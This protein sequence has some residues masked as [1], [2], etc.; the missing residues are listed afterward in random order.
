MKAEE[1]QKSKAKNY[2]QFKIQNQNLGGFK[3]DLENFFQI[4]NILL[5]THRQFAQ[6]RRS[7]QA[8]KFQFSLMFS[9]SSY[10]P[11]PHLLTSNV[12]SSTALYP[13]Q[14]DAN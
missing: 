3:I 7:T 2:L 6:L 13:P 5:F 4:K 11:F 12:N 8:K 1:S 14:K 10:H 9:K